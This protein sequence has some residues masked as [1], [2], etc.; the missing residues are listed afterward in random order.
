MLELYFDLKVRNVIP[1]KM[2][3]Q[4]G[5]ATTT[6]SNED[7]NENLTKKCSIASLPISPQRQI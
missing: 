5:V 1:S 6:A 2:I 4:T 7:E 3:F